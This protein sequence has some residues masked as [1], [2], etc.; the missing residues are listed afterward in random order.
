[1]RALMMTLAVA[2]P[3]LLWGCSS[4]N[5]T[6]PAEAKNA[7]APVFPT[8]SAA[9]NTDRLLKAD[10]EPGSWLTAGNNY[11]EDRFSQL[12]QINET[13]VSQL[14]LAWYADIDTERGQ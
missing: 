10:R 2:A 3:A 14:G 11:H 13:N 5:P 1:M 7:A 4:N 12:D 9:V 8:G 6:V